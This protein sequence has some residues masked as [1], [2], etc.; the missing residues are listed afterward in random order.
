[1]RG[2][3]LMAAWVSAMEHVMNNTRRQKRKSECRACDVLSQ[4]QAG[5]KAY[6]I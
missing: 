5:K 4:I 3:A 6:G 1:M 2:L